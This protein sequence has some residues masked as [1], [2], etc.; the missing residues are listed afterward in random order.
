MQLNQKL[1][2]GIFY[3]RER[4]YLYFGQGLFALLRRAKTV[5]AF[6]YLKH[7]RLDREKI[8]MYSI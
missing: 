7:F 3:K 8:V 1:Y 2:P 5:P 6:I 4:R